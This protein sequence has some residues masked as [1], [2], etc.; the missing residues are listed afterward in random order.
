MSAADEGTLARRHL[1]LRERVG[2]VG[3]FFPP[4]DPLSKF[5]AAFLLR[6]DELRLLVEKHGEL[7]A[8]AHSRKDTHW[9][10]L[11]IRLKTIAV[12]DAAEILRR[13]QEE[14]RFMEALR[15]NPERVAEFD[16]ALDRLSRSAHAWSHVRNT[17]ASHVDVERLQHAL[18][19][20][21]DDVLGTITIS[22]RSDTRSWG[23]SG[24]IRS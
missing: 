24:W 6:A 12:D 1:L 5:V 2:H 16:A 4:D 17:T 22:H 3:A 14:T 13:L 19:D 9:L 15:S 11:L 21:A 20:Y 23:V 8:E 7:S 10:F 18:E